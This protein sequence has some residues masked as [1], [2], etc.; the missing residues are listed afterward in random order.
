MTQLR[1]HRELW[2]SCAWTRGLLIS[3]MTYFPPTAYGQC[4]LKVVEVSHAIDDW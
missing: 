1:G 4:E 2:Q 3:N